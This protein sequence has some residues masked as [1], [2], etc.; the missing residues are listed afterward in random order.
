MAHTVVILDNPE[1][2]KLRSVRYLGTGSTPTAIDNGCIVAVGGLV[3]GEREL[4]VGTT[5]TV[6]TSTFGIV[7]S[8]EV[9][10]EENGYHGLDTFTNEA[11]D[12]IRVYIL[13]KGNMYSITA[14]GF[15]GTPAVG[16]L[17]ELGATVK[18][19]V[20]ATATAGSTQVGKIIDT[21][22][23]NGFTFYTVEIQ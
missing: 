6:S 22:T 13:E 11:G 18:G 7:A 10:Y 21:F 1:G 19:K 3:T 8:E 14:D 4:R 12:D 2:A 16:K 15:D 9:E 17:V 20:V 5:P 23:R